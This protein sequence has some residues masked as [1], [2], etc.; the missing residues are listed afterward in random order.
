MNILQ[1]WGNMVSFSTHCIW[2][3]CNERKRSFVPR[4]ME[5]NFSC[6]CMTCN[7]WM[8]SYYNYVS[9][10]MVSCSTVSFRWYL[11][12]TVCLHWRALVDRIAW[13]SSQLHRIH[14]WRCTTT[15]RSMRSIHHPQLQHKHRRH[16]YHSPSCLATLAS[17][18]PSNPLSQVTISQAFFK[19]KQC[20]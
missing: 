5:T 10:G 15:T 11:H 9:Y 7:R 13:I 3:R 20:N 8:Y 16:S 4:D 12:C 18:N 6:I 1:Y 14:R 19:T 17:T 2:Q